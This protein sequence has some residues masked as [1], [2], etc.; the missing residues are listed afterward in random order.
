M[1]KQTHKQVTIK[2]GDT[3]LISASPLQ[4]GELI[5][6]K[7][8]DLLYRVGA[9]V[10]SANKY[11][12]HVTGH[13]SQEELKMMINLMNPKF[14][15]PVHGEYRQLYAHQKVGV[16]AGIKRENII[17]AEKGDVIELKGNK[18]GLSGKVSAG[19]ILIDGSGV[20]DVGNIVLRDRRLLSQDG[21]L[22]VV[23]TLNRQ[24]KSIA[25]GPEIITRG[26]VYVRESEKMIGEATEIV[27]EI[28]KKMD[29]ANPSIGP[30]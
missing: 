15:I 20:G 8:V 19:N 5:L 13:G 23:V 1:A 14:F 24:D 6:S 10:V 3:V 30:L 7:T 22:I 11:K 26:F 18:M 28:V 29:R 2:K 25:A 17:I 12:V 21:I 9:E 4:G 27:S 16:A